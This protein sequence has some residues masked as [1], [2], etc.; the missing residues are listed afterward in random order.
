[1]TDSSYK[2]SGSKGLMS[3]NMSQEMLQASQLNMDSMPNLNMINEQP[4]ILGGK[5]KLN[6]QERHAGWQE[7]VV[8]SK[9]QII[10]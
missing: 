10:E 6:E 7:T 8:R 4:M 5:R 2:V 3:Q 1:M 9:R